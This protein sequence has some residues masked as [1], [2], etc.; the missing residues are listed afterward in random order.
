MLAPGRSGVSTMVTAIKAEQSNG[1]AVLEANGISFA[2]P[3]G[4][5][6]FE[7]INFSVAAGQRIAISAPSG[8]GKST[9]CQVLAGYAPPAQGQVLF[10]GKP[11]AQVREP[12]KPNPVQLI[13]QH[14]EQVLDPYMRV[15]KSIQEAY[16]F[17][18][19]VSEELQRA[20]GIKPDWLVRFP[21]ELSGGELQRCCIA[22]TLACAPRIIIADEISTMLDA[23]TQVHIWEV[24]LA[25][26]KQNNAGLVLVT[27]SPALQE[28][29]ATQVFVLP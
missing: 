4:A 28:R 26:C 3:Q 20:L 18:G 1:P 2:Y 7:G 19:A 12:G 9:L 5:F 21:H 14:P 17:S 22:R 8:A 15:G 16:G 27:H 13:W 11:L 10:N 25:Y 6:V 23:I 24:L 29:L